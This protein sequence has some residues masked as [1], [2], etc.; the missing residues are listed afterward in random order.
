MTMVCSIVMMFFRVT[1]QVSRELQE[2]VPF[3]PV[4]KVAYQCLIKISGLKL[5]TWSME[6]LWNV[7][8]RVLFRCSLWHLQCQRVKHGYLS[9]LNVMPDMVFR[10]CEDSGVAISLHLFLQP[11]DRLHHYQVW[12]TSLVKASLFTCLKLTHPLKWACWVTYI[13]PSRAYT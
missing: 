10:A 7:K 2:T 8:E 3:A 11:V 6:E 5:I 12:P 4:C 1:V 9:V 13:T